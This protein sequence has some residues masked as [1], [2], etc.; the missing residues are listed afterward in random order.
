MYTL[1]QIL[2]AKPFPLSPFT[3][4]A[5]R[6]SG[7]IYAL[8]EPLVN[9]VYEAKSRPWQR[10]AY[11]ALI[12]GMSRENEAGMSISSTKLKKMYTL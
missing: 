1:S 5:S 3:I 6:A 11:F 12:S 10:T 7:Y 2:L 8:K 9:F 4:F